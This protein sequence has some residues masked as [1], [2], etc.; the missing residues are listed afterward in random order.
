MVP[1]EREREREALLTMR[2]N[3]FWVFA[4]A[5]SLLSIIISLFITIPPPSS[6]TTTI[7]SL[8]QIPI[9]IMRVIVEDLL[10]LVT[11]HHHH[12][13]HHRVK[14]DKNN[15]RLRI[16]S[17]YKWLVYHYR[18]SLILTVDLHGCANFSSVQKAVDAV[19]S[20]SPSKTLI[21]ID[22]ATYRSYVCVYI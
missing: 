6:T 21:I 8:T 22:S 16:I 20:F 15:W 12:H 14:C 2:I 17:H 4:L 10:S 3:S 5:V 19:P 18:V 7:I 1:T 9:L 11:R 13:H